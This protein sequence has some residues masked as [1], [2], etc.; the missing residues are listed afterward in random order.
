MKFKAWG[1][2]CEGNMYEQDGF[3]SRLEASQWLRNHAL[4]EFDI[5][6]E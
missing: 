2:D 6:E 3:G 5:R 1:F 4:E